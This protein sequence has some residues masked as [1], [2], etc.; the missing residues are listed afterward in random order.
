MMRSDGV[1]IVGG[2]IVG[3]AVALALKEQRPTLPVTVLEKE[4][5]LA[6]HASGRNS[7]VLHAGFYYSPDSLKARFTRQGNAALAELLR[8]AGRPA[9]RIGKVVVTRSA[10]EVPALEELARR[11]RDNGVELELLPA[12]RLPGH[13]PY[14]RTVEAY[15]W[16]PT[17]SVAVPADAVTALA[18]RARG[19][20]VTVVLGARADVRADG[21]VRVGSDF[22]RP[23][24]LVN[25]AGAQ[26]DRI[27]RVLGHNDDYVAMPFLGR[28]LATSHERLPLQRLV[29]PVPDPEQ[30]FLGVHLTVTAQG[31][32]KIGPTAIPSLG[33]EQYDLR[34]GWSAKDVLDSTRAAW[35]LVR[36]RATGMVGLAQTEAARLFTR[37]LVADAS[38]LVPAVQNVHD[39]KPRPPGVR[40]QLVHVHSGTLEMDF[41][42]RGDHTSTHVLNA[43]SP[44]WTSAI[45]F[46]AYVAE[47]VLQRHP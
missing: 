18:D 24:H 6:A 21:T 19:A 10:G 22:L 30:P 2:G 33:R 20:G 43:V 46:G 23:A 29:Y 28:Y 32:V 38:Q 26:A 47:R 11:G 13:E 27:A 1:V 41:V 7:G 36:G 35:A 14:A 5:H 39:W 34:H 25:A 4:A 3:L 16:S 8:A 42:V 31:Q 12:H 45:P 44:G 9:R 17:T 15:L 37:R 40:A